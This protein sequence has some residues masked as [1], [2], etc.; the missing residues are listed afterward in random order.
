MAR[1]RVE[2]VE[3]RP[4]G[5]RRVQI[6]LEEGATVRA[7]LAAAGWHAPGA[8][9]IHGQR[10]ALDAPL[11]D[12]DRVEVYRPLRVDPKQARRQRALRRAG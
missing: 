7:A 6:E 1:L 3:A 11:G 5:A 2:L 12:G 8:V 9:G 4:G 10:V